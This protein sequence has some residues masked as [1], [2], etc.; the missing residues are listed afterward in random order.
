MRAVLP[1]YEF[2][3]PLNSGKYFVPVKIDYINPD[4][5]RGVLNKKIE[6]TVADTCK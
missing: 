3:V 4:G 5:T 6:Y 2:G 1:T